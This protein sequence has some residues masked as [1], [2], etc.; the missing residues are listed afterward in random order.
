M[1]SCPLGPKDGLLVPPGKAYML[2]TN[3]LITG[4]PLAQVSACPENVAEVKPSI[5]GWVVILF[6]ALFGCHDILILGKSPIKW[7]QHS[8]MTLAVD[9]DAKPQFK[10]TNKNYARDWILHQRIIG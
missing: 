8:N 6:E 10:Q 9:W 2:L 7:R 5:H 4:Q 3:H 1:G